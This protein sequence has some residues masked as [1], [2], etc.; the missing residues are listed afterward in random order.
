MAGGVILIHITCIDNLTSYDQQ[1]VKSVST[2]QSCSYQFCSLFLCTL[3]LHILY[4][5]LVSRLSKNKNSY[6]L[7]LFTTSLIVANLLKYLRSCQ[8]I[9]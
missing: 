9:G 4:I 2:E 7:M 8:F 5:A 1:W 6:R 3:I